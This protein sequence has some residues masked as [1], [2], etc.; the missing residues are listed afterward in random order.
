MDSIVCG[1]KRT[2]TEAS[3]IKRETHMFWETL[4]ILAGLFL[5]LHGALSLIYADLNF[6]FQL[7]SWTEILIGLAIVITDVWFLTHM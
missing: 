5:V 7:L 4:G 3:R 1:K 6:T 2:E